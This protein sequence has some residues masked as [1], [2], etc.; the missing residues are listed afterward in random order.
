MIKPLIVSSYDPIGGAGAS[1]SAYRLHQGFLKLGIDSKMLVQ[2]KRMDDPT[3]VSASNPLAQK[4]WKFRPVLDGLPLKLYPNRQKGAVLFS[5]QW[6]PDIIN[7]QIVKFQPDIINLRWVC[8]GFL[9]IEALSKIQKPI[10]WTLNDMWSFTGGCYYSEGCEQYKKSCGN[11]PI[12]GSKHSWDLSRLTWQRKAKAWNNLK[13]TL[14]APSNW[15]AERARASSLFS[16]KDI[17]VIFNG[18]DIDKYKPT[19]REKARKLLNL[20]QDK[21]L[22][23]FG[24]INAISDPRKGFHLLQAALQKLSKLQW[25]DKIELIVFGAAKPS[26]PVDLGFPVHYLGKV[27]DEIKLALLYSAADVMIVPSTEEVFGQTASESLACS[28]P[29]VCFDSTGLKDLVDHQNNGYRAKYLSY[30]DLANGIVWVIENKQRHQQ[31]CQN[32]RQK[33]EQE[34]NIEIQTRRYLSV[35]E[36]LL[37]SGISKK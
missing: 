6:L 24:A 31:L 34:F 13:F 35:F 11:C 15:I 10:V 28:T 20:P 5:I 23:L 18:L 17:R 27:N 4:L 9:P 1:R 7:S 37:E 12:L 36:E 22:I 29:V 3:I 33:A 2:D 21:Q 16:N 19:E 14:V 26:H 8:E 25:K 30:E 32:A